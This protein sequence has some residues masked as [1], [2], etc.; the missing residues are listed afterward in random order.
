[1][2]HSNNVSPAWSNNACISILTPSP[3]FPSLAPC[4]RAPSSRYVLPSNLTVSP[5]PSSSVQS[6]L[7]LVPSSTSLSTSPPA[8]SL[9]AS[10]WIP[11]PAPA[12]PFDH[13]PAVPQ[14]ELP[15]TS[16][17]SGPSS[18]NSSHCGYEH[19]LGELNETRSFGSDSSGSSG[20]SGSG[21]TR[22]NSTASL[23]DAAPATAEGSAKQLGSPS[24]P[25]SGL[26]PVESCLDRGTEVL[27]GEHAPHGAVVA[28]HQPM[29]NTASE[30]LASPSVALEQLTADVQDTAM[31]V[32]DAG[33]EAPMELVV[34]A[35]VVSFEGAADPP[36]SA[37]AEASEATLQPQQPGTANDGSY[38][39][40]LYTYALQLGYS[41]QDAAT[42][43]Q[44]YTAPQDSTISANAPAD[45]STVHV[46]EQQE[47]QQHSQQQEVAEVHAHEGGGNAP[48]T[49]CDAQVPAQALSTDG[50][51]PAPKSDSAESSA[52]C[53][54]EVLDIAVRA[55]KQLRTSVLA[56]PA[57][58]AAS[59]RSL[60]SP[61]D[62]PALTDLANALTGLRVS[63]LPPAS[64]SKAA[65]APYSTPFASSPFSDAS[66]TA[67]TVATIASSGT[68]SSYGSEQF[69]L[70]PT[71]GSPSQLSP[72]PSL[73]PC[74]SF[75]DPMGDTVDVAP[76]PTVCSV[77]LSLEAQLLKAAAMRSYSMSAE[78]R[79]GSGGS[80][81]I[82]RSTL[83]LV[84]L[85]AGAAECE[86]LRERVAAVRTECE[87]L[88]ALLGAGPEAFGVERRGAGAACQSVGEVVAG[89]QQE[90]EVLKGELCGWIAQRVALQCQVARGKA[91]AKR[92]A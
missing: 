5:S 50:Q 24:A 76:L 81:Y 63:P 83:R 80:G 54:T 67:T 71:H 44:Y 84:E 1:M 82:S 12:S 26:G 91:K 33:E 52:P 42:Y 3:P 16:L 75:S 55:L 38:Y 2:F 22:C 45:D 59:P 48:C 70:P 19:L 30:E 20:S 66:P 35:A 74:P 53:S 89:R 46:Q 9:P 56:L 15:P 40:Y 28:D 32:L 14:Q 58:T 4:R 57:A 31:G 41:E 23:A 27:C 86:V 51:A 34:P 49:P 18:T 10:A 17:D 21:A 13:L 92:R 78:G 87:H 69:S 25:C 88:T 73:R 7:P 47:Q 8:G 90:A 36:A 65:T 43:A 77:D 72:E 6:L 62:L 79:K 39:A 64:A 60:T 11:P 61:E 68:A 85:A 37:E 29:G